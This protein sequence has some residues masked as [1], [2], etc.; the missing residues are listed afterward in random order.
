MEPSAEASGPE[1]WGRF[2]RVATGVG[3]PGVGRRPAPLRRTG[4]GLRDGAQLRRQL[5][6]RRRTGAP[7]PGAPAV[8]RLRSRDGRA[9]GRGGH[10]PRRGDRAGAGPGVAAAGAARDAVRHARWRGGERHPRKEPPPGRH[11]RPSRAGAGAAAQ[12]REHLHAA[13]RRSALRG[14]RGGAGPD[15]PHHLGG[16]PA[17]AGAERMGGSG[18]HPLSLAR[19]DGGAR[20]RGEGDARPH[21]GLDRRARA[22]EVARAGRLLQGQPGRGTGLDAAAT[23]PDGHPRWTPRSFSSRPGS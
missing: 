22:G 23:E 19:G 11:V 13:P 2:P 7:H 12:R 20:R 14:H 8:H 4:A 15:R 18:G 6:Q 16:A 1:S 5:P 9:S 10:V 3:A 21:R 17:R